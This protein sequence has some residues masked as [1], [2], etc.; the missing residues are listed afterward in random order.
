MRQTAAPVLLR[1]HIAT[2]GARLH[3]ATDAG[4]KYADD[5]LQ[6]KRAHPLHP[7]VPRTNE[8]TVRPNVFFYLGWRI[9][10]ANLRD[11][12]DPQDSSAQ[13][14][15]AR[16]ALPSRTGRYLRRVADRSPGITAR[17]PSP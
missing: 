6:T 10:G 2:K 13:S 11:T 1:C 12:S 7:V 4:I 5:P 8:R 9:R 17:W 15:P 3:G 14:P 16:T